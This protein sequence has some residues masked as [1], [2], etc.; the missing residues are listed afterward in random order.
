MKRTAKAHW[1]GTLKEGKGNL[2]TQS[3]I[4]TG[5]NYSFKTRFEEG[6]KGTNPEE[7]LAAAHAGCFTMA[8]GAIMTQKGLNPASLDTEA[9]VSMEGLSVTG[10][11]LNITGKV[12][13]ISAEEFTA[14][15][16]DA[17]KN[18]IISKVL[19]VPITSEAHFVA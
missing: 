11:H 16:K 14:I 2:T 7:L 18:C 12:A 17:E 13:G 1:E 8:V 5:T 19:S 3:G 10:I 15:T 6:E 4:L 9:T